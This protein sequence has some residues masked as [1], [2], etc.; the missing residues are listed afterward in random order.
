MTRL[1]I[2]VLALVLAGTGVGASAQINSPPAPGSPALHMGDMPM[3]HP[4]PG[5]MANG[6]A[7]QARALREPGQ[8]A[9]GAIQ[10]MVESLQADPQTD[11]SKVD[12]DALREHL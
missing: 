10:E 9:F 7:R 2:A 11:W 5:M 12:V 3:H 8:A 6:D 4:M 1:H